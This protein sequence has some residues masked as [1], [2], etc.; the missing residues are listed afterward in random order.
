MTTCN[1]SIGQIITLE[2]DSI[3]VSGAPNAIALLPPDIWFPNVFQT[4]PLLPDLSHP[5]NITSAV[6]IWAAVLESVIASF[7]QFPIQGGVGENNISTLSVVF[8]GTALPIQRLS[9]KKWR[10][11][12]LM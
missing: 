12:D 4:S 7:V 2:D 9:M 11:R 1:T 3:P 8:S 6:V 5:L 10:T